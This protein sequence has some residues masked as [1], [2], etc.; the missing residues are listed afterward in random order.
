MLTKE[1]KDDIKEIVVDV[2]QEVVMPAFETVATKA[3]MNGRFDGVEKRLEAV[4]TR[5]D[6]V[7]RK[8]DRVAANQ[9]DDKYV[10]KDYEKRIKKLESRRVLS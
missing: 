10:L 1:D 6:I 7:D 5:L 8:L 3:E 4:E 9:L 2:I